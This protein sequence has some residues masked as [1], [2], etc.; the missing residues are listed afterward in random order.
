M[1]R[2]S[3]SR[4]QRRNHAHMP[5]EKHWVRNI[6]QKVCTTCGA[7]LSEPY[8]KPEEASVESSND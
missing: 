5:V 1:K 6:Y 2:P 3:P 7:Y 4:R 8:E